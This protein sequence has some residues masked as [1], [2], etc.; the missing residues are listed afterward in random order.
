[1]KEKVPTYV[2]KN[3]EF[4]QLAQTITEA[5]IIADVT[6]ATV[7]QVLKRKKPTKKGYFF[8]LTELTQEEM[9]NL[10]IVERKPHR[11][12]LIKEGK[13]CKREINN[14]FYE[15]DCKKPLITYQA[16]AKKQRIEDLK[17]FIYKKLRD[18]WMII[19]KQVAVL[20]KQYIKETLESLK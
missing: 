20:E 17:L 15:V 18:R 14:L 12:D 19:P 1:M 4:I 8:S 6:T 7:Y 13:G 5:S 9:N 3:G 16:A 2:Y 11:N 10:P